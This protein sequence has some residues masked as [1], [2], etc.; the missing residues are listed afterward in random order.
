MMEMPGTGM[1]AVTAASRS[2]ITVIT[3][4]VPP[5]VMQDLMTWVALVWAIP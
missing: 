5:S 1:A 3:P 2:D 4:V